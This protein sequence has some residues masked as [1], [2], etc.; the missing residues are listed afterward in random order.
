MA[1][2][3]ISKI[4][5]NFNS[6]KDISKI[7]VEFKKSVK[8]A[9]SGKAVIASRTNLVGKDDDSSQ[10][11]SF[12]TQYYAAYNEFPIVSSAID[13]KV[14]Q[15][16][17][18]F[19]IDG[20]DKVALMK[21]A[22]K[23]NFKHHM[24]RILKNGLINGTYWSELVDLDTS[25]KIGLGRLKKAKTFKHL[26]FR[27]MSI[28]RDTYGKE[29]CHVQDVNNKKIYWG[30]APQTVT[31]NNMLKG[32]EMEDMF[33]FKWNVIADEKYGTSVIHSSLSLL[34]TKAQ[35]EKDL[36]VIS[37]RY[38]APIIHAKVGDETH[39]ADSSEVNA[40]QSQLED[41]YSDTEYVTNHLV[42]M[43]VL[44]LKNKGVDFKPLLD[45]LDA[46][47][48]TGL[49]THA[50]VLPVDLGGTTNDK[51]SEIK[52]RANGRSVREMQDEL[53]IA[54]EDQVFRQMTGS[55][56]NRLVFES[57]EERQFQ[58][59]VEILTS[60]VK[61]G[62]LT[63]QKA[64]SLLPDEYQETLPEDLFD[65]LNPSG[66]RDQTVDSDETVKENPNNPTKSTKNGNREDK[67]ENTPNAKKKAQTP[68]TDKM[69]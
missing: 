13:A 12:S 18:D 15:V 36:K 42:S 56:K 10:N 29:L 9:D 65:K 27:T 47:I 21:W 41:I 7:N 3:L 23:I 14:K 24:R 49:D 25:E 48:L 52:L 19:R 8:E 51:G 39:C 38:L 35:I 68:E 58:L 5:S 34:S 54:I 69:M 66:L 28:V 20:P 55:D 60:L 2:S 62:I 57:V 43:E 50:I 33:C 26:D 16:V 59:D 37:K 22:D 63:N 45:H 31:G 1:N 30:I 46:Q 61:N 53:R 6:S 11:L 44:E 17:Q 32:G 4:F 67:N 40:V 64:N